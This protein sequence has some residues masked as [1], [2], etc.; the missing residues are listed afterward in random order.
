MGWGRVG[1]KP[2]GDREL[3][4]VVKWKG[5]ELVWASKVIQSSVGDHSRRQG[6]AYSKTSRQLRLAEA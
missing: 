2:G 1:R 6:K 4:S 3:L 5:Y